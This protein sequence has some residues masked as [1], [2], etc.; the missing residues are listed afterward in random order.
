[1]PTQINYAKNHVSTLYEKENFFKSNKYLRVEPSFAVSVNNSSYDYEYCS[2]TEYN[3]LWVLSKFISN[4]EKQVFKALIQS[5]IKGFYNFSEIETLATLRKAFLDAY[6]Q[7]LKEHPH[8]IGNFIF[9][10]RS[11]ATQICIEVILLCL[12]EI[13]E[14]ELADIMNSLRLAFLKI[15][16]LSNKNKIL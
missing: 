12:C 3:Q 5:R 2:T 6:I 13:S 14:I 16:Q 9:I 8:T 15:I 11:S 4:S 10:S 7:K 1:M